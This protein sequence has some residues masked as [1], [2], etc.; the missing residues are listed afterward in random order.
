VPKRHCGSDHLLA[1]LRASRHGRSPARPVTRTATAAA[2]D[3]NRRTRRR[4]VT[5]LPPLPAALHGCTI[6]SAPSLATGARRESAEAGHVRARSHTHRTRY[7]LHLQLPQLQRPRLAL[8]SPPLFIA[9]VAGSGCVAMP[10]TTQHIRLHLCA[11]AAAGFG[12]PLGPLG[13]SRRSF[14]RTPVRDLRACAGGGAGAG[15]DAA[16]TVRARAPAGDRDAAHPLLLISP[17][18]CPFGWPFPRRAHAARGDE[19]C[20]CFSP[21][22]AARGGA[23]SERARQLSLVA[24]RRREPRLPPLLSAAPPAGARPSRAMICVRCADDARRAACCAS[25][26][27]HSK[28]NGAAALFQHLMD[29]QGPSSQLLHVTGHWPLW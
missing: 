9:F 16:G 20:L 27:E 12:A 18:L 10:H 2:V 15:R 3:A 25:A 14:I 29:H 13:G 7:S 24:L 21:F 19:F 26:V 28:T 17:T 5:F 11:A 22:A 4:R 23:F 8:H 1:R 6:S